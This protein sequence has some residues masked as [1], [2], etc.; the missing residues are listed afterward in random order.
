MERGARKEETGGVAEEDSVG[1]R[2]NHSNAVSKKRQQ[3]E[4]E[5][6]RE[7][8]LGAEEYGESGG[9][10]Y[11]RGSVETKEEGEELTALS[12]LQAGILYQRFGA[13]KEQKSS[14]R[15]CFK[16]KLAATQS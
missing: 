15:Q 16:V 3:V 4:R 12:K 6:D 10:T 8:V 2:A 1:A 11:E 5:D 9:Q 7:A 14:W 13:Q